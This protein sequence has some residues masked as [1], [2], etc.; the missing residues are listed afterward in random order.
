MAR[1]FFPVHETA[2]AAAEIARR[3]RQSDVYIGVL[4]RARQASRR[5]DLA[6]LGSVLWADCD[7]PRSVGA[8][9]NFVPS[10]S[11]VV[12]SGTGRH[13]YWLLCEPIPI[14]TVEAA[15]RRLAQMLGA[16]PS[17]ADPG[18]VL[19]PAPSRSFK[20][21][22]PADVRLV[23]CDS[24]PRYHAT[25]V[26]GDLHVEA[27]RLRTR[28]ARS[29][30]TDPLLCIEPAVY[31]ERL[32]GM[33]VPRHR[34]VVCPFHAPD[35]TPSLHVYAD[36]ARGWYCFGCGRGGS[37]YDLAAHLWL[38]EPPRGR[39]FVELRRRLTALLAP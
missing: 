23:R 22:P 2:A 29:D 27:V 5:S 20:T 14:E 38:T 31:V 19:R 1:A 8:L 11:V 12:A 17:C 30:E 9:A 10:P 26:A 21:T 35:R 34:K 7:T 3:T 33:R 6:L 15:N 16:D 24:A 36:P 4:P 13:G 39:A 25:N 37:V 32:T 28:L 18:R